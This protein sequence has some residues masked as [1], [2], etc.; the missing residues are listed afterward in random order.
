MTHKRNFGN[1]HDMSVFMALF[2]QGCQKMHT[3]QISKKSDIISGFYKQNNGNNRQ[4]LENNGK[5]S[6]FDFFSFFFLFQSVKI[7]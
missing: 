3:V 6:N 4:K 2:D 5:I 7:A 1:F